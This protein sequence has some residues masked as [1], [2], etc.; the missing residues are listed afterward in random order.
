[1]K[2]VHKK[3][4]LKT[5]LLIIILATVLFHL[6]GALKK[7]NDEIE[8][9][10]PYQGTLDLSNWN[11]TRNGLINLSGEWEFYWQKLLSYND[12]NSNP[13]PDL[14]AEVPKVWNSYK[15]NGKS[16]PGFGYATY[17]LNIKNAQEGQALAIRMPTIST[18]YNLY[19]NDKLIASNG[20][21]GV[22]KQ[23]FMPEYHPVMVEFIP[24]SKNFD[25]IL[26]AANFSYARGG[27]WNP[28]FMG[29]AENVV[30]Y[31]KTIGYKDMFLVGAFLIMAIYYLCIFFMR[32]EGMSSLYFT[33]LCL[34]A[35][36]M[37]IIYGDYV[38][39]RIFPWA[40]YRVIVAVD[41]A[42]TTWA[43]IVLVY[44][45][46]ELFPE[47]TSPKLKKLFAIYAALILLV[48]LLFPI[49]IYTMLLYPLQFVGF[50]MLAYA[51]VCV[52]KA[53]A[54]NKRDSAI[55]MAGALIVTMGGIHDIFYHNNI[56]SSYFG[57]L[58]SFGFLVF[59]FLNA[60]ILARRFSEAFNEA[61]L[62]SEKLMK[63]DKLKD[64]F[65][66]NTS[67]ELR[68][69]LNAMINIAEVIS[70]GTEGSVNENQKAG[71]SM[72]AVS[73]K[74]LTYLINDIIDYSK[75]KNF[76]LK[77]NF[78]A[79]NLKRV[80]ESVMNVLARLNKTDKVQM[81][82]DIPD[83]LPDIYTDENRLLQILY[84]LIGNAQKFTEAGYIKVSASKTGDFVEICIEDTGIGIPE[85]KLDTIFESF[86]QLE[87]S[88]TRKSGGT[89][90]GLSITKY[91]VEAH[92]GKMC[93]QSKVGEGTK[94]YFSIPVSTEAAEEKSCQYETAEAEIAAAGYGEKHIEEFP[95]RYKSD[96][97]HIMLVDDNKTNLISLAGILKMKNYSV[98]AVASSEEFFEEFKAAGDVFLVI[99]DVMLPGLS[100]YEIC[101]E[102]RK[103]YSVFELP[104]LMLT[105]RTTTQDIV[106]GME[107]GANDYLA[108]PFDTDELLA[109][110][111]TLIQ[112]KQS[113]DK[114]R[115]SELAFLQAQIKPHFLYNALN[116][117]VSISL[118]DV[119]KARNLITEFGNYLRRSFDF[120][121][122]SQLAP[123]KNELELV[124]AYLEIEKA[125]FEERIEVAYDLPDDLEARVPILMLQPIVENAVVHGI[126]PKD[127]GGRIEICIKRDETALYF[128]VKDNGA[129]MEPERKDNIFKREFGRGVGL[130]NIDNRLKKLYGK[131]LQINSIPGVGTEVTWWVP[132]N[133]RES[134]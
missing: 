46:G 122:L 25:I 20:K 112:L 3:S 87:A 95:Y 88:L 129:G 8:I 26:Q 80:A 123:L 99:L 61:K 113:V 27:V 22:D 1:M 53:Y 100:G 17:R 107:A 130:S 55:I 24:S 109:R 49:H 76:E 67:H 92:G 77:M 82:I 64:E 127:E 38:I 33:L 91:L 119:D 6:A 71:L 110:V 72:I 84:N 79:V 85:D 48:I 104:V 41:Y 118:Y 34:I 78:E 60:F 63:L 62:L 89:G 47:Q 103:N 117:F 101:R 81:L 108:K 111:K 125:R 30:K 106:M 97:P 19:I 23:H 50:A 65:L 74:R 96:G 35:I 29:F 83:D 70:R 52:A 2:W 15:I 102:I 90:L 32:K 42:V 45:M 134:E 128:K 43:P 133:R 58:S 9:P 7:T 13:K 40:G 28:I 54:K 12:L 36:C 18:A 4:R 39:N 120:K 124:R 75:L 126:L 68:T 59:L 66:A 51:V 121:D 31:D 10:S 37:T 44:L 131:G 73:G 114:A 5:L 94:F 56:I 57:E 11:P 69:P 105:A 132:V 14:L 98:T 21:V 16:L 115:V 116:T 93:V 86:R